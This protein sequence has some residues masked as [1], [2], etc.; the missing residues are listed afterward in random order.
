M[1][2]RWSIHLKI[3][4][5]GML[6]PSST[7]CLLGPLLRDAVPCTKRT[8]PETEESG[9]YWGIRNCEKLREVG[10]VFLAVSAEVPEGSCCSTVSLKDASLMES[11]LFSWLA[12]LP[13]TAV[14]TL[15]CSTATAIYDKSPISRRNCSDSNDYFLQCHIYNIDD[16]E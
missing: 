2:I 10:I 7:G 14:L 13:F 11:V 15:D 5:K 1:L 6:R 8:L 12:I 9:E 3:K 16:L 4:P